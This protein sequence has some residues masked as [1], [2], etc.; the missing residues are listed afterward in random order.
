MMDFLTTPRIILGDGASRDLATLLNQRGFSRVLIVTDRGLVNAGVIAPIIE[1]LNARQIETTVFDQV[2]ADPPVSMV[3]AAVASSPEGVDCV[4]GIGGGSTLDTSKLVAYL[5]KTPCEIESIFGVNA[6]KGERL[7]LFLV[8]TTAGTG[9]EVTPIAIVTSA[10][11]EKKGIVAPQLLPDIAI[12]DPLVTLTVP[13]A[14]TAAGA[15]DA[16]VHAIEAYTSAIKKNPISDSLAREALRILVDNFPAVMERPT[17]IKARANMLL[18]SC[19]AGMAFANAP[20][21]AVHAL[22]YPLG[23]RRHVPHGLSNAL[24]L[25]VVMDFNMDAA[26]PL[27]AELGDYIDK[28]GGGADGLRKTITELIELSNIPTSLREVGVKASDISR[29]AQD[30]M[31][32]QRLLV[33]NPV[34][35]SLEDAV[36]LYQAV[37]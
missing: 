31:L 8:P 16:M 24:M 6:A 22:A 2:V 35:V 33:N 37:F 28:N 10:S 17:D 25:R 19:L 34:A 13:P 23:A 1:S 9:S 29:L 11:E 30:A 21:G 26:R 14:A 32:Q 5:L 20:V 27:Y 3:N 12:L 7:P 18:G 4:V 15:V 36:R